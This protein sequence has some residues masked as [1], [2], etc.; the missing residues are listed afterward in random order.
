M[1]PTGPIAQRFPP[2]ARTRPA[3]LPLDARVGRLT[4]LADTASRQHDPD[5]A[6]TVFNQAALLTSSLG[7]PNYARQLRHRHAA[8]HLTRGPLRRW[9]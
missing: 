1:H 7:L 3:C 2:V 9:R 5:L 4:E 8:L 6:S